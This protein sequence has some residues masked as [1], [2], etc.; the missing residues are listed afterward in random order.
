MYFQI[1]L[2]YVIVYAILESIILY[3][4]SI[5]FKMCSNACTFLV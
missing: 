4:V 5:L 3:V 1:K 2:M